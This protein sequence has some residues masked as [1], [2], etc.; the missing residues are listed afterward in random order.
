MAEGLCRRSSTATGSARTLFVVGELDVASAT[1][2]ERAVDGALDGPGG[3]FQLDFGA[4]T[5]T[6]STGVRAVMQAHN[7]V[8]SLGSRMV[9]L[10][11]T[12]PVLHVLEFMGLDQVMDVR[13]DARRLAPVEVGYMP[14]HGYRRR[15]EPRSR[16][17]RPAA[18][19]GLGTT[20]S[21]AVVRGLVRVTTRL[22][23]QVRLVRVADGDLF[24]GGDGSQG[25]NHQRLLLRYE[26]ALGIGLDG[27]VVQAGQSERDGA[28]ASGSLIHVAAQRGPLQPAAVS[29]RDTKNRA[30][31]QHIARTKTPSGEHAPAVSP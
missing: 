31:F 18:A 12:A 23:P 9:I 14:A 19:N 4:L 27:V 3:E 10:S 28:R 26:L 7:E 22:E 21:C 20:Y 1:A 6:E 25:P 13:D 2:F 15:L 17:S 11:P 16:S 5:F 30:A 24:T 8:A 29:R